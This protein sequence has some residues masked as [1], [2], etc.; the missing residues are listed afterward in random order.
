M[1]TTVVPA[2]RPR[3][4]QV[5]GLGG[6]VDGRESSAQGDPDPQTCTPNTQGGRPPE[7]RPGTPG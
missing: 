2:Q 5:S 6:K 3:T 1:N 4:W 7:Q